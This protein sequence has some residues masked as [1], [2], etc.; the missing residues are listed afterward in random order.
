MHAK[1]AGAHGYF[2]VTA[3]GLG[4]YTKAKLFEKVGK[5]TPLL[6]RFS[7][8]G[9][10]KGSA[11]TERDPRGFAVKFYT[12]EGNWDMT[13]NNT[14]VFFVR[15]PI[16]FPDFIHT[17]KKHPQTNLKDPDMFW[18]FLGHSPESLHQISILFSDR[19]IPDGFRFM[20][21]FSSHALRWVNER[22][23]GF[24]VKFH[25]KCDQGIKN[26]PMEKASQLAGQD[27]DYATRDLFAA[28][29]RK[30]FPSWTVQ[31]QIHP[32]SQ[33]F[34]FR[35]N[36]LDVTKIWPHAQYPLMDIGKMVLNRNPDN[37]FAE[38]E[39]A[40]FSPSHMV[41]GIEPSFDRM[42]QGRLFSY[43]DTHRHRLGTN[44]KQIPVNKPLK[45]PV[46]HHQRD[47]DMVVNGNFGAMPNYEPNSQ[48]GPKELKAASAT[49]G[50]VQTSG[51]VARHNQPIGDLDFEHPALLFK[52]QGEAGQRRLVQA[53]AGSMAGAKPFIRRRELDVVR[54]ADRTWASS[55]EQAIAK[56]NGSRL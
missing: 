49:L 7:T 6:A 21:G 18:D 5:R 56:I 11:D 41:P 44:Y 37:Y 3:S 4:K 52:I 35:F 43:P 27:P 34:P 46:A 47:G 19:G 38:I 17:Q 13:G 26:L 16:K 45:C 55:V 15:D 31:V 29:E 48:N 12:E 51:V 22:G 33:P 14:P 32:E 2:E 8:V 42:L 28:I 54:R 1:G 36:P 40:A 30:D 20:H 25:F 24:L 9:G 23:E 10:E 53:M 39:Q 50:A